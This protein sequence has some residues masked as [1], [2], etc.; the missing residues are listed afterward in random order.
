[1]RVSNKNKFLLILKSTEIANSSLILQRN[2]L[3]I[4]EKY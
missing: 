3:I 1:M 2:Y 4:K